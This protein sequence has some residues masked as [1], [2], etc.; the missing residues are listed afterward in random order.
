M[1]LEAV[2][3][4]REFARAELLGRETVLDS[5]IRTAVMGT[6]AARTAAIRTAEWPYPAFVKTGLAN[7]WLPRS[8]GGLGLGL[9]DSVDVAAELAYGDAGVA[10][11]SF[12]SAVGT[13][14]ISLYGGERLIQE[15]LVPMAANGGCC[16]LLGSERA[17]GSELTRIGTSFSRAGDDFVVD[18]EK[19]FSTNADS[20]DFL[21]VLARSTDDLAPEYLAIVMPRSTPGMRIDKRWDTIGLRAS[22]VHQV[23]LTACRVP[24]RNAL[25][26]NGLR[27]LEVGLNASRIMIAATAIGMARRIRDLCMDYAKTKT[28]KGASLTK[29]SVFASKLAQMEMGIET[30]RN[31]CAAAAHEYDTIMRDSHAAKIFLRQGALKSAVVAKMFCGQTGWQIASIGSEMF[32]GLGYTLEMPM[33]KLLRDMRYVSLVEGG[34]DVLR[35]LLFTR[36]VIPASKRS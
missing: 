17:A 15:H 10:F 6:A 4:A 1:A 20:A 12:I 3:T 33:G 23:T 25:A 7:W 5:V 30:M 31:Q 32:G 21:I 13:S 11:T 36:Y 26:G 19:L 22:P 28:V 34:D 8:L 29:N 18:G 14:M 24:G 35:E 2:R 16:A 27:L 9:A